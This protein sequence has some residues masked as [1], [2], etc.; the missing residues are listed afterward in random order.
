LA[1]ALLVTPVHAGAGQD[2]RDLANMSLEELG[3]LRITSVSKKSEPLADAAASVFVITADDIRRSGART[4]PE[5]L[6]LAPNL[7]VA[8]PS[9]T[10][11]AISA[12][13]MNGSNNSAPNK[14]LV[15]IDGRSVYTPLFSGV[16]WDVQ[17]L[18]PEDIER[19]EVISGPGGTL[20]GVNAV[21]GVINVVTRPAADTPGMLLAGAT[22]NRQS[23][24]GVRLGG[25]LGEAGYRVFARDLHRDHTMT[26][27]GG[28]ID[29]GSHLSQVGF[30]ADWEGGGRRL[31]LH[32]D[33]Y[34]GSEGQPAPGAVA[35]QG[36]AIG[37][38]D[39]D[40]SGANLTAR[41]E[42]DLAAGGSVAVQAY[43]DRTERT[44]PP[45]F[46]EALDIV[47][48][49][50]QHTLPAIGAHS[51]AWGANVRRSE[52]RIDNAGPYFA[53]LPA[54]L[55][56]AWSSL[57]AQD[58]VQ[59]RPDLRFTAGVRLERNDYTGLEVLPNARLAWKFAPGQLLWS[60]VSRAVR[61]PS[62][63]DRDAYVPAMPPFLLDGGAEVRSEV[64]RVYEL[65]YRA[66]ADR[67]SFSAT[68]FHNEYDDLRTQEIDPGFTFITFGSG[69]RGR[70]TGVEAWGNYQAAPDWR[71]SAGFTALHES[72]ELKPGSNDLAAP[73]A[74]GNDPA[75][76]W[77]I[78]SS[79]GLGRQG[80][81]DIGVRHV[82]AL[83]HF[84]I[85]AYTVADARAAW[86]LRPGLQVSLAGRNLFNRHGEYGARAT[87]TFLGPSVLL[88]LEWQSFPRH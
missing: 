63:L 16:F 83:P 60:A 6:R 21:N 71:L 46:S 64:A 40:V 12:R 76:T 9:A 20:W 25:T 32:G 18:L 52:D 36:V 27:D 30:R 54:R 69:M 44:V 79:W 78:R 72:L 85:A 10:G 87:R 50:L 37:L 61:A 14:L 43:Y 67:F 13:G 81:L 24:S 57:F 4:L 59:L 29:D 7:L 70:A 35:I 68:A 38:D 39:V 5:I 65:G 62:R 8:Q 17:D 56:Q 73:A 75:R 28:R 48:L 1:S 88:A 84:G 15:L 11:Y 45:V 31:S 86:T 3:N 2:L 23:D 33:L 34:R 51:L 80:E 42:R 47:D 26:E 53:F 22:G 41:W 19:I 58:E 49:Q 82:A 55:S 66:S 74:V 77:Q